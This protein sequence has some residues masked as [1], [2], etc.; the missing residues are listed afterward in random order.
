MRLFI[1]LGIFLSVLFFL[2][3]CHTMILINENEDEEEVVVE[4][5]VEPSPVVRI[6]LDLTPF[7][8]REIIFAGKSYPHHMPPFIHGHKDPEGKPTH[9]DKQRSTQTGRSSADTGTNSDSR[10][11]DGQN[12]R[13]SGVRRSG[14]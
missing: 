14:R 6:M 3:G 7:L 1:K 10:D 8:F 5:V 2:T 12:T 9:T 11:E 13:D 4:E